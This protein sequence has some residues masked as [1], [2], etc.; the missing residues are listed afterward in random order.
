MNMKYYW[1][2]AGVLGIV[3]ACIFNCCDKKSP[4][5]TTLR[6]WQTETDG[7]A[8]KVLASVKEQFER[9][10]PGVAV[11]L[12]SVA[13]GSLSPKLASAIQ[14]G[15]EP[16]VAHLEPFMAFTFVE[17]NLLIPLDDLIDSIE[18]QNGD[19][20]LANVRNLQEYDYG[21]HYGIAYAVG[22]TAFAYRKDIADRLRLKEPKTW[23]DFLAFARS[24]ERGSKL[25]IIL[26]GGDPFFIDQ[27]FSEMVANN[28]GRLFDPMTQQPDLTSRPVIQTLQF[29]KDLA[30]MVDPSWTSQTYL[31]QFSRLGKGETSIVMVLY[32]RASKGI[33]KAVNEVGKNQGL[34]ASPDYFALMHQP[35]GP[36]YKG[37]SIATID[38]EPYVIFKSALSRK[39][40][41]TNNAE[42]GK[43]FLMKF[44]ET[45]NYVKFCAKVPIHLTPIFSRMAKNPIYAENDVMKQWKKWEIHS[46]EY[47][48]TPGRVRPILMP[49]TTKEAQRM[50]FLMQF[51][52]NKI[53]TQA[54]TDV[55]RNGMSADS[56]AR[57]AQDRALNLVSNGRYHGN[58]H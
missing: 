46:N 7:E 37:P 29:F 16:D 47:L 42:L 36:S 52:A 4:E 50:P 40:K 8:I 49:D 25:K 18:I 20:I 10:N 3:I 43:R 31:D 56:A 5:T 24:M 44:Y 2:L 35:V 28:G 15:S 1:V 13:W 54:V 17:R 26:P 51:Q 45:D 19:T 33:T 41:N 30:P 53:L 6:I 11:K 34:V 9:E 21:K 32:G 48:N 23:N 55:I 12:E 58:S 22:S 14:S 38:C 27:L 39:F 57:Q